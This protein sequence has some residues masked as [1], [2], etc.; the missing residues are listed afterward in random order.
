VKLRISLPVNRKVSERSAASRALTMYSLS[1][2]TSTWIG[3]PQSSAGMSIGV[4]PTGLRCPA[5]EAGATAIHP[6]QQTG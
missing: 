2:M 6:M 3:K 5:A 4:A 1:S